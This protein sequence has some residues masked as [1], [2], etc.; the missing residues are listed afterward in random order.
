[1]EAAHSVRFRIVGHLIALPVYVNDEGPFDFW[2]DT[3]GPGIIIEKSLAE[4]LGLEVIDTG[5]K[6]IGAGG[7]VP[8]LFTTVNSLRFGE[9]EFKKIHAYVLDLKGTD[10]KYEFK[11]Y[12]CIGYD[13]LKNFKVCIDYVNQKLTLVKAKQRKPSEERENQK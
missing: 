6:G 5:G 2:L 7:E 11:F 1:M 13:L 8:A 9:I 3:A 4:E 10:E 12:G